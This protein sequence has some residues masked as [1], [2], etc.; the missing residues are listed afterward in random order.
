MIQKLEAKGIKLDDI[1]LWD[2]GSDHD[3]VT[4]IYVQGGPE[5]IHFFYFDY[6][7]SGK[8]K[9]GSIHGYLD[10]GFTQTVCLGK[11]LYF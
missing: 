4:K 11:Y 3:G 9:E 5:G 8:R 2:D 10:C 6:V 7:K 1:L